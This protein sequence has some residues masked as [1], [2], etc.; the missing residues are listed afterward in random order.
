MI[1][2]CLLLFKASLNQS[3]P[4]L[5]EGTTTFA[6]SIRLTNTPQRVLPCRHHYDICVS[7]RLGSSLGSRQLKHMAVQ[8]LSE[9]L[10]CN[11][12]ALA[13][14]REDQIT[15]ILMGDVPE[16]LTEMPLW[17]G[18]IL[19][20]QV[21]L[22]ANDHDWDERWLYPVHVLVRGP[23]I[24]DSLLHQS[25]LVRV[26]LLEDLQSLMSVLSDGVHPEIQSFHGSLGVL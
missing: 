11:L 6:S 23:R 16:R 24:V 13:Q 15:S 3:F 14:R 8:Q 5:L 22:G 4:D 19:G 25:N 1:L 12:L 20:K 10:V 26:C 7:D 2:I 17:H 18:V 21:K 9:Q